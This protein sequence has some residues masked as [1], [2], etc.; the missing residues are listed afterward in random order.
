MEGSSLRLLPWPDLVPGTSPSLGC[1][2]A[3]SLPRGMLGV[4]P[5]RTCRFC[6][7]GEGSV[8]GSWGQQLTGGLDR[9]RQDTQSRAPRRQ[10]SGGMA[11]GFSSCYSVEEVNTGTESGGTGPGLGG[12]S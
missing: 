6:P 2:G 1:L 12:V 10:R 7:A 3:G 8:G 5:G 11:L 4:I 9:S